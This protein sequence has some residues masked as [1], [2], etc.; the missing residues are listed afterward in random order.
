MANT[1]RIKR[2]TGSS[3]PGSLENAELAFREGDEVLVYGKGTGG[4]GGSATSI[5]EIGGTGAFVSKTATQ[6]ANIVL[7]GPTTGSAAA[8]HLEH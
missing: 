3:N 7:A 2:S 4:A 1:I 5:I 8:L 6:N